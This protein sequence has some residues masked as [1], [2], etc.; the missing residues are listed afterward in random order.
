[1]RIVAGQAIANSWL[2]DRALDLGG[3]LISM[4]SQA[5]FVGTVVVNLIRVTSLLTRTSWQLKH[6]VAI[7]E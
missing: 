6:P 5:E 2:V 3:I 1:V 4:T 7:A